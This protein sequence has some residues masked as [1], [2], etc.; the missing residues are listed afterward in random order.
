MTLMLSFRSAI[1]FIRREVLNFGKNYDF[2]ILDELSD[3]DFI[4]GSRRD[5]A[6]T[7]S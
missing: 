1:G 3:K 5:K 7:L 6:V 4:R 2:E